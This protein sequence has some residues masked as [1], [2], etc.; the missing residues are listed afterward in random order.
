MAVECIFSE[1]G[2]SKNTSVALAGYLK[3]KK[4]RLT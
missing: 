4:Q 1:G 2:L 3:A